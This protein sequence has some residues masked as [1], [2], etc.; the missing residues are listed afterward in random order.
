VFDV[1]AHP[2]TILFGIYV[3]HASIDL[4][5]LSAVD[6]AGQQ[7]WCRRESRSFNMN[8]QQRAKYHVALEGL[9]SEVRE[10][11]EQGFVA[12]MRE[13]QVVAEMKDEQ[14]MVGFEA[15]VR[16]KRERIFWNE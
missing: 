7:V 5:S 3:C 11:R 2:L 4:P 10:V 8:K 9:S 13:Q 1:K 12:G 15:A 6:G 16:S 14:F